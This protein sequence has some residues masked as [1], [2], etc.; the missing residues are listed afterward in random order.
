MAAI[1]GVAM[2]EINEVELEQL[3]G[4]M[5][6]GT[7]PHIRTKA[8]A[9]WNLGR[10]KTGR[11]V[12][13]FLGVSTTS[14]RSWV[15]R[16]RDG[17]LDG[18]AIRPGRGRKPKADATEVERY[19]RQS[20]RTFGLTQ[21]RWTL[22]ALAQTVPSLKGFSE[23]GVWKVLNRMGYRYKRGQP[24][25]HSPDPEY[26]EKKGPWTRPSERRLRTQRG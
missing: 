3:R 9:L 20:P 21:T 1:G 22:S 18:L 24:H 26:E 17:G 13:D 5:R 10:G 14:I 11:E 19:L 6:R 7:Q 4:L 15:Q 2:I 12:A 25:L 8:T 16:F 23:M